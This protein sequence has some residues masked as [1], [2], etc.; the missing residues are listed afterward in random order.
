[1]K[2]AAVHRAAMHSL[3]EQAIEVNRPTLAL[4]L[5]IGFRAA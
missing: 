1:M 2:L 4:D 3:M 5:R